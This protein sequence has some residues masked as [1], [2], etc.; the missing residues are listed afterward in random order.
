[1]AFADISRI[2][3]KTPSS[4]SFDVCQGGGCAKVSTTSLSS[5]DWK[6][7]VKTLNPIATSASEERHQVALAIGIFEKIVGEKIGTNKDLAGTFN[8]AYGQQDCNDE[9]INTTTYMRLLQNNGYLNFH[10]IEDL[11]TR[12][13]FFNGWPHTTAVIR[14]AETGERFAVDSWFYDNGHPATIVPFDQWKNNY[15]PIDS[16]I[17]KPRKAPKP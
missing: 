15:K 12:N 7:I 14:D 9:A 1:M 16:P 5:E 2:F 4:E 3:H 13:F 17:G 8:M 10:Q 6:L 11:R